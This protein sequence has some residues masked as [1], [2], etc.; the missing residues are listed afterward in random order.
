MTARCRSIC[1]NAG[2]VIGSRNRRGENKM[3]ALPNRSADWN[4]W[5][6]FAL[7]LLCLLGCSDV[8]QSSR[9]NSNQ[10]SDN[11]NDS[12]MNENRNKQSS[13]KIDTRLATANT[14]FGFKLFRE[15][16]SHSEGKNIFIS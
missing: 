11:A 12:A 6:F 1:S 9:A 3:S 5:A 8:S 2:S 4:R 16:A 10:S 14:Q 13:G 7:I 15:V